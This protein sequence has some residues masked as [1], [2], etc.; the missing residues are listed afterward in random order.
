M[1]PPPVPQSAYQAGGASAAGR[2]PISNKR[3]LQSAGRV[4][5]Q[6]PLTGPS[7]TGGPS[8]TYP[9]DSAST[10]ISPGN[11]AQSVSQQTDA[12]QAYITAMQANPSAT[13]ELARG[14]YTSQPPT[15]SRGSGAPLAVSAAPLA[16]QAM[17]LR[18]PSEASGRQTLGGQSSDALGSLVSGNRNSPSAASLSALS[19]FSPPSS[20][21]TAGS[22]SGVGQYGGGG[23]NW[24]ATAASPAA[25]GLGGA[26]FLG[27][28]GSHGP[29]FG[30]QGRGG[31]IAGGNEYNLLR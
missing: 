23:S 17:L 28:G 26:G 19:A 13:S 30:S 6:H 14:L 4:S 7:Q 2:L 3:G 27:L 8:S 5:Q 18:P 9:F 12:L 15:I 24:P 10:S 25:A 11:P 22:S 1:S 16:E 20:S 29:A 31:D 21:L